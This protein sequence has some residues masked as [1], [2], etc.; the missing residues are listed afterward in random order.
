MFFYNQ[1]NL[2]NNQR[3]TSLKAKKALNQNIFKQLI[4][5]LTNNQPNIF[6]KQKKLT[7]NQPNIPYKQKS[8]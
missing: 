2:T 4:K 5:H 1:K 3:N 8:I 7:N 6:Y